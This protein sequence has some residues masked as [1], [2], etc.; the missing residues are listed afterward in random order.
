M[1]FNHSLSVS[2]IRAMSDVRL[3]GVGNITSIVK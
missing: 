3:I 2:H 1:T